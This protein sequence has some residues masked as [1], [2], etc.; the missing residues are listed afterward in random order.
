ME[1]IK[2]KENNNI[3]TSKIAYKSHKNVFKKIYKAY[4]YLRF[5]TKESPEQKLI[6]YAYYKWWREFILTLDWENLWL[7]FRDQKSLRV[8]ANWYYDYWLCQLNSEY[9]GKF[10]FKNWYNLKDWFSDNFKDPIQQIDY[11]FTV[12]KDAE[13]KKRIP[14]TFYAYNNRQNKADRFEWL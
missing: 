7:W 3:D 6:Q 8:W 10:I 2:Q 1:A 4:W 5:T 11:C 9:H 13:A 12:W 14:T